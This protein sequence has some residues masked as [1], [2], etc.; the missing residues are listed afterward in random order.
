MLS[1]LLVE[2]ATATSKVNRY[3]AQKGT[4]WSVAWKPSQ[5]EK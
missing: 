3:P 1:R 4:G 5:L 2:F